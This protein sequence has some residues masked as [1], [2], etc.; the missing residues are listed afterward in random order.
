MK[1]TQDGKGRP[2][3]ISLT[4]NLP[5]SIIKGEPPSAI[6]PQNQR[7]RICGLR[8]RRGRSLYTASHKERH[9]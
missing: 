2:V 1:V 9:L 4:K 5:D 8:V 7:V 3:F 6:P